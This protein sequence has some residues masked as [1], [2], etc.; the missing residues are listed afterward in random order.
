MLILSMALALPTDFATLREQPVPR[1]VLASYNEEETL[2][3]LLRDPDAAVRREAVRSL[4]TYV[5]MRWSTR[6][7]VLDVLRDA[8]EDMG[9]RRQAAKTLAAASNDHAVQ[10]ALLDQA[11][12]GDAAL[13]PIAYKSLHWAAAQRWDVRDALLDAARRGTDPEVRRAAVWGLFQ[14]ANDNNVQ[15][16]LIDLARRDADASVRDAALRSL[17]YGMGSPDVR[18]VSEDLAEDGSAPRAVRVSAT[19][20]N[21]FRVES[22][23]RDLLE[24]LAERDSDPEVRK[25]AITALGSNPDAVTQHFHL[26]RRGQ[27]GVIV[28][29]PLD[30]E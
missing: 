24:R 23:Q 26:I 10:R 5:A 16:V 15:R 21:A 12:R 17:Y 25:A 11:E 2:L 30:A 4:K 7:R 19:L 13:R 28:S 6:D 9:V 20:L 27:N 1:V 14:A 22:R 18:R 29:D 3:G 8:R